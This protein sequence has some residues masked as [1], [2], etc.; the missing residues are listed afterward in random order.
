DREADFIGRGDETKI[1]LMDDVL[2]ANLE[3]QLGP[4]VVGLLTH[5]LREGERFG[6]EGPEHRRRRCRAP[7]GLRRSLAGQLG[8][9]A[10]WPA[11]P[12]AGAPVRG[13]PF[14][15]RPCC[16]PDPGPVGRAAGARSRTARGC[17]FPRWSTHLPT[18]KLGVRP[19]GR[20]RLT[21]QPRISSFPGNGTALA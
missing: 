9:P 17:V 11:T 15:H 18:P 8:P 14:R 2:R 19:L 7:A 13:P 10:P 4:G 12:G 6:G 3:E 1:N 16:W 20:V 21:S 5:V